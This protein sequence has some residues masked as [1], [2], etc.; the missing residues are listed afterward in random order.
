MTQQVHPHAQHLQFSAPPAAPYPGATAPYGPPSP[1]YGV[2]S[3]PPGPGRPRRRTGTVIGA[4]AGGV[5]TVAGLGVAALFAFGTPLLDVAQVEDEIVRL[6]QQEAGLAPT[7]VECPPDI[8]VEDGA[9]S[10]CTAELDGQPLS[11]TV[12]QTD[13]EGN[14]FIESDASWVLLSKVET[15]LTEQVGAEAG[16]E[17]VTSCDGGGHRVLVDG[18]GAPIPCTVASAEDPSDWV[19]VVATVDEQGA[20]SYQAP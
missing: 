6:T 18:I 19:D 20:V 15:S 14:V 1:P 16:V 4:V 5:V 2:P 7:G 13:D 12:R 8:A 10:T 9:T 3:P 11:Y 17:V